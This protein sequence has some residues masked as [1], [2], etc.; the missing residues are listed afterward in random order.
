MAEGTLEV[1]L[2]QPLKGGPVPQGEGGEARLKTAIYHVRAV[3]GRLVE[4]GGEVRTAA[5]RLLGVVEDTV[6]RS[7]A[8]F[9]KAELL[10]GLCSAQMEMMILAGALLRKAARAKGEMEPLKVQLEVVK[11]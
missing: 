11:A 7:M 6:V 8:S 3:S 1:E 9:T 4:E 5:D 10:R 2:E